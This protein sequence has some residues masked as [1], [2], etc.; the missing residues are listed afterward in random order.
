MRY[1]QSV[2][3]FAS[4]NDG[5]LI[6]IDIGKRIGDGDGLIS[7]TFRCSTHIRCVSVII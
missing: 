2:S 7:P 3:V 6:E 5:M 1:P 4:A